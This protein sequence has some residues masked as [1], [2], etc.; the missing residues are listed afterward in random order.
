MITNPEDTTGLL[1]DVKLFMHEL[2]GRW[3]NPTAFKYKTRTNYCVGGALCQ[4]TDKAE[5]TI[6]SPHLYY[7]AHTYLAL[8]LRELNKNLSA[9]ASDIFSKQLIEANDAERMEDAWLIL[10]NA[11]THQS[12]QQNKETESCYQV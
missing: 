9:R 12:L 2:R 11:L 4:F 7:P 1:K 8:V 5:S 6:T 10:E 3:P